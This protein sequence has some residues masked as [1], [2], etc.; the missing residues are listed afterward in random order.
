MLVAGW[1]L[2]LEHGLPYASGGA[3]KRLYRRFFDDFHFE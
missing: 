3:S 1:W 2:N